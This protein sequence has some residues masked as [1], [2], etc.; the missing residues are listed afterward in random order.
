MVNVGS[1]EIT[2]TVPLKRIDSARVKI[3][4]ILIFQRLNRWD[5]GLV[6]HS[7]ETFLI[8]TIQEVTS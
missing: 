8:N 4:I 7:L 2:R 6:P 1:L 3:L 5:T